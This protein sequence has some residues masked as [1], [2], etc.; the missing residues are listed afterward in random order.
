MHYE[1]ETRKLIDEQLKNSG[2][3]ADSE[4]LRQSK[5]ARPERGRNLAIAEWRTKTGYA[6][7]ALFIGTKLV[8]LIE[9]KAI[10]KDISAILDCQCRDYAKNISVADEKY[11]LGNWRGY[12]VPFIFAAN[13]RKFH[14]QL[15][16]KSGVWFFDLRDATSAPQALNDW[17]SPTEILELLDRNVSGGNENLH[18]MSTKFLTSNDGLNL[19]DYQ[20]RAVTAAETAVIRGQK[21]ILLAMATGTGKTR[22]VL[23][24]IYRFLKSERFRRILFLV[25]RTALGEQALDVFSE[26]KLENFLP[27]N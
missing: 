9:A 11:L 4:T 5:G 17:L 24:M 15:E 1:S 7:Y 8:G 20:L 13:G 10:Y 16:T 6:D 22:T 25:D 27:L 12:R 21:N 2:W 26:V 18:A 23:A 19:R 14:Q 3:Y